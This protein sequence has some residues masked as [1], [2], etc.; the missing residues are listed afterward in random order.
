MADMLSSD[1]WEVVTRFLRC[2]TSERSLASTCRTARDGVS[3]VSRRQRIKNMRLGLVKEDRRVAPTVHRRARKA[4]VFLREK[5]FSPDVLDIQCMPRDRS[6]RDLV[7]EL[8]CDNL[9]TVA[10]NPVDCTFMLNRSERCTDPVAMTAGL[11][12]FGCAVAEPKREIL[13]IL[14]TVTQIQEAMDVAVSKD[15]DSFIIPSFK[16]TLSSVGTVRTGPLRLSN[17]SGIYFRTAFQGTCY[18]PDTLS[19]VVIGDFKGNSV[20]I[21]TQGSAL[22]PFCY[23]MR[24]TLTR[25]CELSIPCITL[26]YSK[27]FAGKSNTPRFTWPPF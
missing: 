9:R 1:H 20:R 18:I 11:F 2:V 14:P 7:A 19:A 15:F 6:T 12:A 25:V 8:P 16:I 4:F 17:K 5:L 26:C 13:V 23:E 22:G 24:K 10:E 3:K 27:T 21:S